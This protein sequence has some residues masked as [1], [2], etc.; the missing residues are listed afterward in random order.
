MFT[1]LI[2]LQMRKKQEKIILKDH[3]EC[4]IHRSRNRPSAE[5]LGWTRTIRKY[6]KT[7]L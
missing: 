7:W 6:S 2:I 1:K 4:G 5:S 3:E